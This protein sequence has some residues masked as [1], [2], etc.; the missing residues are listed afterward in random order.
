MSAPHSQT[1]AVDDLRV[2]RY[3][4]AHAA[5]YLARPLG[6]LGRRLLPEVDRYLTFFAIARGYAPE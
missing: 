2:A 4:E 5:E 3:R 6:R 1:T